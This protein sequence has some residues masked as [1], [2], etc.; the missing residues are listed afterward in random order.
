[1]HDFDQFRRVRH[2][3]AAAA[4]VAL[5]ACGGGGGGNGDAS[6]NAEPSSVSSSVSGVAAMGLLKNA[7][8]TA[9][10]PD[11]KG[12]PNHKLAEVLT[13]ASGAYAFTGL[14]T[15]QVI[16]LVVSRNPDAAALTVMTDE[17][18]NLDLPVTADF[19]LSAATVIP[20]LA[21]AHNIV[22]L[23]PYSTMA[24]EKARAA[25]QAA[26]QFDELT[27]GK[28][29]ADVR[30]YAGFDVL[31]D[32]PVFDAT[33][34]TPL[35]AA[36]FALAAVSTLAQKQSAESCPAL[37][38]LSDAQAMAS[39]K[40]TCQL[41]VL[42]QAGTNNTALSEQL[43]AAQQT[44]L[45]NEGYTGALPPAPTVQPVALPDVPVAD[46]AAAKALVAYL[47]SD[48]PF[49]MGESGDTLRT[50]LNQVQADIDAAINPIDSINMRLLDAIN[51][52]SWLYADREYGVPASSVRFDEGGRQIGCAFYT[53]N[54]YTVLALN[55]AE[56][57]TQVCR[58]TYGYQLKTAATGSSPAV[59]T[60]L[61]HAIFMEPGADT[62]TATGAS[63]EFIFRT[64]LL[65]QDGT[66]DA[67]GAFVPNWQ[68]GQRTILAA[69]GA[70]DPA[71]SNLVAT[72]S[73][74]W[75]VDAGG[76]DYVTML[77][78]KGELAPAYERVN[79]LVQA[80][81]QKTK[82][83]LVFVPQLQAGQLSK[84]NV[85]GGFAAVDGNG[86]E[87]A[88]K[89]LEGSSIQGWLNLP[90]F[91][92]DTL[93][94]KLDDLSL[95]LVLQATTPTGSVVKGTVN[96][97]RFTDTPAAGASGLTPSQRIDAQLSQPAQTSFVGTVT[98]NG[99]VLVSGNVQLNLDGLATNTVNR[100]LKVNAT[101]QVP[102]RPDLVL[103]DLVLTETASKLDISGRLV[104]GSLW[105]SVTGLVDANEVLKL[106]LLSD[107]GVSLAVN[108]SS[109]TGRFPLVKGGNVVGELDSKA[110]QVTF[111][112]NSYE[113][114]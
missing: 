80:K 49:I 77:S 61:Q 58:V 109:A 64:S 112:D 42:K 74:A 35:N 46:I 31:G 110:G 63:A 98:R 88:I 101:V 92:S 4:V 108:S 89:L 87:S 33:G 16:L 83:D 106:N 72:V 32:A 71:R 8:V 68:T 53:D 105:L 114:F 91:T 60:A 37:Q 48:V 23:T 40:L 113:R 79:G 85:T 57:R 17:A 2:A 70:S 38:G 86:G 52:A 78:L 73:G 15:G 54:S 84:L 65:W 104:Q 30:R 19:Q 96:L 90:D 18:T 44:T 41:A 13:D 5:S 59:Y 56:R 62:D 7:Q 82:V 6:T 43:A 21:G 67:G 50:R 75:V 107:A 81:G 99:Q 95:S 47:R 9:Y 66:V 3:V 25:V 22:Q 26:G 11:A 97:S 24:V 27:V 34:H 76:S 29:N 111:V 36:A 12:Q 55:P 39:V 94:A 69:G 51:Y 28:A 1:M 10:L 100:T 20:T 93:L 103:Q 45:V 102:S 14:P